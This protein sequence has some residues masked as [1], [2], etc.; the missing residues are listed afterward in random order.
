MQLTAETCIHNGKSKGTVALPHAARWQFHNGLV[1]QFHW[2][3]FLSK[4]PEFGTKSCLRMR[5]KTNN[6]IESTRSCWNCMKIQFHCGNSP[7]TVL[8]TGFGKMS[9]F[10]I[11]IW[12]T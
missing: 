1:W 10:C 6:I 8:S 2:D 11:A 4:L 7:G 3:H 12:A 9:Y 5:Q